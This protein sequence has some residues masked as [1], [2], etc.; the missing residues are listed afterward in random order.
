[1]CARTTDK[2]AKRLMILNAAT[3]LVARNGMCNVKVADIA[4][5]AGVGKGTV[6]EYFSSKE[7]IYGT[8]ISEYLDRAETFAARKMFRASTQREKVEAFLAGW[9]EGIEEESEEFI[10]LFLDVWTEGIRQTSPE[11]VK[12]F[13]LRS[14]FRDYRDMVASILQEGVDSGELRD[15]D[16]SV[17]AGS[18]LAMCDGIV[19]Q[20]LLDREKIDVRKAVDTMLDIVWNGISNEAR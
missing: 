9:L 20:Y 2:N 19:L 4:E 8:I 11:V 5:A 6:Y 12:I 13:D 3:R 7:E 1:M 15:V 18:L 14:Y 10:M 16:T 17:A